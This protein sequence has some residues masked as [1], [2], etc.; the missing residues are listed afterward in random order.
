MELKEKVMK[1]L[2]QVEDPE[3][4]VDIVSLGLVY[5]V[6]IKEKGHI[7]VLITLTF[8]GCPFGHIIEESIVNAVCDLDEVQSATVEITFEPPWSPE[9]IDPDIRAALGL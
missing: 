5:D 1:Q 7:H 4:M 6:F 2:E 3:L 9:K 8:P